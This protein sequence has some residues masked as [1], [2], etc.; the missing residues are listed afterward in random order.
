VRR[1]RDIAF[2]DIASIVGLHIEACR[3]CYG[4]CHAYQWRTP[5]EYHGS[6]TETRAGF[7]SGN[8]KEA[9]VP[10]EGDY[11]YD[12]S[13]PPNQDC[14]ECC[15]DGIPRIVF[16]D[17]RLFTDSERA[18]FAGVVESRYGVNY[19]F[20]DRLAAL[21]ELAKRLG[22]YEAKDDRNT[23]AVARLILDLQSR[24]QMQRMPLRRDRAN[25]RTIPP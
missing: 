25:P 12:A 18:V 10:P 9:E 8:S 24:G 22:F 21:G 15:G 3:F 7:G 23:N 1:F 14:P 20:H 5:Q 17:T 16:K 11:G 13:L 19:R 6:R 4:I 2:A